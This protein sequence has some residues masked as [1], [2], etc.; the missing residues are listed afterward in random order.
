MFDVGAGA[1]TPPPKVESSIVRLLP[2][3]P[4]KFKVNAPL[5]QQI[6]SQAFSQRRKTLRNSL[7]H[8][9]T[10][11]QIAAL[12]IDPGIRPEQLHLADFIKLAQSINS[13]A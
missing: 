1:F 9:L 13:P 6:V 7:K 10:A 3:A 4:D 8:L 5:L 2:H 12:D 11:E